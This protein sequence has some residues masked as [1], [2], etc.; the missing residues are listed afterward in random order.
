MTPTELTILYLAIPFGAGVIVP[1]LRKRPLA[2]RAVWLFAV[3]LTSA[4]F[5][6]WAGVLA[7]QFSVAHAGFA[8]VA[9]LSWGASALLGLLVGR[10][11][12]NVRR[13]AKNTREQRKAAEIFR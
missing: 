1:F 10:E 3:M 4:V 9:L 12:D 5:Y 11:A 7:L 6:L 13:D 2:R 8:F